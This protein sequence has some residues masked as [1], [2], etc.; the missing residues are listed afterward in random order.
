MALKFHP[1]K[2]GPGAPE[3]AKHVAEANFH[4]VEYCREQMLTLTRHI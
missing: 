1:D 2:L 4:K 3:E